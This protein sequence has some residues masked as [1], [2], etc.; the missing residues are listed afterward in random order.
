MDELHFIRVA[1]IHVIDCWNVNITNTV[2]KSSNGTGISILD[3]NGTVVIENTTITESTM[4][5]YP[6]YGSKGLSVQFNPRFPDSTG[7]VKPW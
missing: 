4:N 6:L 3:T 5:S 7:Y 1:A 2:V